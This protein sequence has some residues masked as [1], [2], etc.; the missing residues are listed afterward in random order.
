MRTITT[1]VYQFDELSD[2][3]KQRAREWFLADGDEADQAWEYVQDDAK[4]IGLKII[5]LSDHRGNEGE[6]IES[7]I[8]T[9]KKILD[10]HGSS[11]ETYKTASRYKNSLIAETD[12]E[13]REDV[14]HE[15]LH[16]LLED[17][18]VMLNKE[19]EYKYSDESVDEN[20][21]ANEYEFTIDGKRS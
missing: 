17:Y 15:F 20:I 11:C 16:D 10:E 4:E 18:R 14:T 8:G 2:E 5:S 3:A 9:A 13:K 1:K 7:A 6:F 19:I 21:R 12:D